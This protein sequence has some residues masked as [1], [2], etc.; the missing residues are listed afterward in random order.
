M[1]KFSAVGDLSSHPITPAMRRMEVDDIKVE[2][3]RPGGEGFWTPYQYDKIID[4]SKVNEQLEGYKRMGYIKEVSHSDDIMMSP[5][6][7]DQEA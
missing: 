1:E 3:K 6:T 2:F 5:L 4:R 7:T